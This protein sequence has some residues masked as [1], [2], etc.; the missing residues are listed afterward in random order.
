MHTPS[1]G[2][3]R[4]PYDVVSPPMSPTPTNGPAIVVNDLPNDGTSPPA[5]PEP[6]PNPE[7]PTGLTNAS[8]PD[9]GVP[10]PPSGTDEPKPKHGKLDSSDHSASSSNYVV[11]GHGHP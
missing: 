1:Q 5:S 2:E 11:D 3:N 8:P 4:A 7:P 10:E 6:V 9:A